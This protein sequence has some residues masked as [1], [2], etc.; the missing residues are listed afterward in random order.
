MTLLATPANSKRPANK[1]CR[2]QPSMNGRLPEYHLANQQF[3]TNPKY[4]SPP[5]RKSPQ[6]RRQIA[7]LASMYPCPVSVHSTLAKLTFLVSAP[8]A[9]QCLNKKWQLKKCRGNSFTVL[10][11]E[12]QDR[13]GMTV[14]LCELM[15]W[16]RFPARLFPTSSSSPSLPLYF[17]AM[18]DTVAAPRCHCHLPLL[19]T[20]LGGTIT[21]H[22]ISRHSLLVP[23]R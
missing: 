8:M 17:V 4:N 13:P 22:Q 7:S 1:H 2:D 15:S 10:P 19:D 16:V 12:S 18:C 6:E 21:C 5:R 3:K 20:V 9:A 11:S 23:L 14:Q